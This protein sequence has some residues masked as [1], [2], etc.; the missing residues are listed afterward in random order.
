MSGRQCVKCKVVKAQPHFAKSQ[1]K[2]SAGPAPSGQCRSCVQGFPN[3]SPQSLQ[4]SDI[5]RFV[6]YFFPKASA[7]MDAYLHNMA[8]LEPITRTA[9]SILASGTG[10]DHRTMLE[11]VDGEYRVLTFE[12]GKLEKPHMMITYAP[13]GGPSGAIVTG[14]CPNVY[15]KWHPEPVVPRY[16]ASFTWTC[17]DC[18]EGKAKNWPS[19]VCPQCSRAYDPA[20]DGM[21]FGCPFFRYKISLHLSDQHEIPGQG[22]RVHVSIMDFGRERASLQY[23]RGASGASSLQ[24]PL[25]GAGSGQADRITKFD[26]C[27]GGEGKAVHVAAHAYLDHVHVMGRPE[28]PNP[29]ASIRRAPGT[30]MPAGVTYYLGSLKL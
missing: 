20:T 8:Y 10:M 16:N 6:H 21:H 22:R 11:K 9:W 4:K 2:K 1:W 5:D 15:V 29:S 14:A 24:P 27:N 7:G 28:A 13:S 30:P 17:P 18:G 3:H 19:D 25:M 12:S 23:V 26:A